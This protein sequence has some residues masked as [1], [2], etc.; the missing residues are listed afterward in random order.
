MRFLADVNIPK[1]AI[2]EL[3]V[4]GHDVLDIKKVELA[5][6]DI[7]LIQLAKQQKRIILTKDKDFITLTQFPKYQVPTI[8]IRLKDQK[9][10]NIR[11]HLQALIKNQKEKILKNSLTIVTEET[12]DSLQY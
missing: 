11:S 8:T 7:K 5:A 12:A 3:V 1:S 9:P 10:D 2:D 6:K 4:L